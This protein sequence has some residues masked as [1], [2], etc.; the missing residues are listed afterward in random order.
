MMENFFDPKSVA[1][2]GASSDKNKVGFALVSNLL[3]GKKREIYPVTLTEKEILGVPAFA[4]ILNV[5]AQIDLAIIA[6]H[7]E[8]V[9]KILT[10]CGEKK[11]PNAIII[12]SGFKEMGSAGKELEEKVSEIAKNYDIS[13]L[14]PNCLGIID[15]KNNLNAS[16]SV[17]KPLSGGIAFLSQSGALG[18]ALIDWANNQ[19]VGIS[20]FISLGNEAQLSEIEF[21]EYLEND[22]N[23]FAILMYLE[24]IKNG[25][26]FLETISRITPKKTVV[27]IKAG[28][29][30]HGNLAAKSHTG[31]LVPEA[32][33]FVSACK[34]AGAVTVS[35][36]RAFFHLV[37][38][39]PQVKDLSAPA[40]RLVILT[41]GG[42]PS[43]VAADLV[44]RSKSLSLSTLDDN[45]KES[46]R[47]ILPAMAAVGNPV[48]IIGDA[49]AERYYKALEILS[50]A[51][52]VDGII[53]I[54]TPQMMTDVL[55]TSKL[56]AEYNRMTKSTVDRKYPKIFPV[57]VGGSSMQV[58]RDELIKS[59]MAYFTFPRDIIESL[60][61]L[62]KGAPKIKFPS[63]NEKSAETT[64]KGEMMKFTYT[65]EL[66]SKYNISVSG[67]FLKRKE[68]LENAL[69]ECGDGP[70]AMKA[71][72]S[73]IVHKTDAGTVIL[74]I[75]NVEEANF[76]WEELWTKIPAVEGILVQKMIGGPA[77][78]KAS[79]GTREVI[80]GMKRDAT[81]GPTVV[82]GLGG[83]L[84][85]A[86]KDTV[87]RVAPIGK[88]EALQMMQEIKGIKILQGMRGEKPVN[89]DLLA[90][91]IIN[92]SRLSIEHPEIK[93]I[94]LNPVIV[95]DAS[96]TVVDVRIM[97]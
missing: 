22:P 7:A 95:T 85:E 37:K 86:I 53:V 30:S 58:G 68:N 12:S 94:D 92:L 33:V 76:V 52:N 67:K 27:I 47:K 39:L 35:S 81:F 36:L 19:G 5:P 29:G 11:I 72:S 31:A 49:L 96:A 61:Y 45:T 34:Q 77:F 59:G 48:D 93:E 57:L 78:A 3:G 21:L 87:L 89:F 28:M 65:L 80:V 46:L 40:Q 32:G 66:L 10:E 2:I 54:L 79:A 90:D 41:N 8:M 24:S 62:A 69:R 43:V 82:F 9:P 60:D 23:T 18:T 15:V 25:P 91:I 44:D 73:A 14:G 83:I 84:A 75:K 51:E 70:Y 1:V 13:V 71:I 74:N 63:H 26:K 17:Q 42:G 56:L 88:E 20:K 6:V 4:S 38:I 16:F 55:G 64:L 97:V 50:R